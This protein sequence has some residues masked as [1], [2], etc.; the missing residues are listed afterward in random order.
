MQQGDVLLYEDLDGGEINVADGLVAMSGGLESAAYLSLFGGNELDD[1]SAGSPFSWWGNLGETLP[2]RRYRSETQHVLNTCL[3][4]PANLIKVE[5]A[6]A[7]D[8]AWFVTVGA[9][10]SVEVSASMPGVNRVTLRVRIDADTTFEYS[11]NWAAD[12]LT[13]RG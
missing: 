3:P 13:Q 8:L 4:Q 1:G 9:A 6:A 5:D 11:E 7:R 10:T 2:E 12:A